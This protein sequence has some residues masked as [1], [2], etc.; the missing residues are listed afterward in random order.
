MVIAICNGEKVLMGVFATT[1]GI[2]F[3]SCR[4]HAKKIVELMGETTT[5][6]EK[7]DVT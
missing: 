7:S 4:K 1:M 2:Y 6:Q 5:Q 3:L